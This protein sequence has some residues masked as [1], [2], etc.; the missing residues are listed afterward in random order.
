MCAGLAAATGLYSICGLNSKLIAAGVPAS[1]SRENVGDDE[2]RAT[3]D[4]EAD[5]AENERIQRALFEAD[6][7]AKLAVQR[8]AGWPLKKK[9]APPTST[10]PSLSRLRR[11]NQA[12]DPF[13]EADKE[14]QAEILAGT[15]SDAAALAPDSG[16][17]KSTSNRRRLLE[18]Q[19][20]NAASNSSGEADVAGKVSVTEAA[21]EKS[22]PAATALSTV[23]KP[24]I[25]K[26]A[27]EAEM[28]SLFEEEP[29]ARESATRSTAR[30][31]TQA[32]V[33]AKENIQQVSEADST[34]NSTAVPASQDTPIPSEALKYRAQK[35]QQRG[36]IE[37][38]RQ[39]EVAADKDE[40]TATLPVPAP[41]EPGEP[42]P[43]QAQ[44]E[45]DSDPFAEPPAAAP[46]PAPL[47][48]MDTDLPAKARVDVAPVESDAKAISRRAKPSRPEPAMIPQSE[49][50]AASEPDDAGEP[51][52]RSANQ[53][54]LPPVQ[55]LANRG[56]E[57]PAPEG[58]SAAVK[59]NARRAARLAALTGRQPDGTVWPQIKPSK[60]S[61][62]RQPHN[63]STDSSAYQG[64]T[65]SY[66]TSAVQ[67]PVAL[68]QIEDDGTVRVLNAEASDLGELRDAYHQEESEAVIQEPAK[69]PDTAAEPVVI[70]AY[71]AHGYSVWWLRLITAVSV[72]LGL[73]G[74]WCCRIRA[75]DSE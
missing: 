71:A 56:I 23:V 53:A 57:L 54:T 62:V 20:G 65:Q 45:P 29:V 22:K 25:D 4:P 41:I 73:Y 37:M 50:G 66:R 40:S 33:T 27:S 69:I 61:T 75:T 42:R 28:R 58:W 70:A 14:E 21:V 1:E 47:P 10:K 38:A 5:A 15:R 12:R 8:V 67:Q 30:T 52:I 18:F 24:S 49:E 72:L 34:L 59:L 64:Q 11:S 74:M 31:G 43:A 51:V 9:P 68:D 63:H 17:T 3:V 36:Q 32:P 44:V 6:Q 13:A 16:F 35:A 26:P 60:S 48:E 55:V 2:A 7:T 39:L 19:G 46:L